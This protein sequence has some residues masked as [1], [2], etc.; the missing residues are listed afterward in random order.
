LRT[1]DVAYADEDGYLYLVDRTKDL[2][3]VSGFNV[4]PKEVEDALVRL[5]GVADAV[6]VGVPDRRTGEAVKA[7]VVLQ[8][9]A[10]A[11]ARS[12]IEG[13]GRYLARFKVPREID[14][15]DELPRHPTGKVL[16]RALRGEEVLG[17]G[18]APS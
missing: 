16:R 1:G 8:Q 2:I 7:L 15:V 4:F 10:D 5:P 17:G 9:D 11:T 13:V 3:I 18:E 14:I 6:V 12:L